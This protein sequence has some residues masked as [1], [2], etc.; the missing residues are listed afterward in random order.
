MEI[1]AGK[2]FRT[3]AE[4]RAIVEQTMMP[5]TSVSAV[6][7]QHGVNTNQ[8]FHWRRQYRAGQ[9]DEKVETLVPVRIVAS[10]AKRSRVNGASTGPCR[11]GSI[12]IQFGSVRLRIEGAAD[13]DC[14]RAAVEGLR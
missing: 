5:R 1:R 2:Q 10:A 13:P 14:V 8:V 6:A 9:L 4:R 11:I 7:R 12:E 3:K